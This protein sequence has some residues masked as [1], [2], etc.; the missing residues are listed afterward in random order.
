[1]LLLQVFKS[2]YCAF[3]SLLAYWCI[4]AF[5]HLSNVVSWSYWWCMLIN[6]IW[7]T[8]YVHV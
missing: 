2:H 3:L 6:C 4:K 5:N 1:M 7:R 8:V